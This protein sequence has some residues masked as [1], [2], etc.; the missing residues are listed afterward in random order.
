MK[1]WNFK[2]IFAPIPY[3]KG[4]WKEN[5]RDSFFDTPYFQSPASE[6]TEM[7]TN[8]EILYYNPA[9]KFLIHEELK[10]VY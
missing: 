6:S 9:E 1:K 4:R 10:K 2:P 5:S 8:S 3:K 7:S